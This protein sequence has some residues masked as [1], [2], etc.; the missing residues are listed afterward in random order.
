[1]FTQAVHCY[2]RVYMATE[3][4]MIIVSGAVVYIMSEQ[5]PAHLHRFVNAVYISIIV[6][7][8]VKYIMITQYQVNG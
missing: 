8:L 4:K 6:P 1:M 2:G 5:E 3:T 7:C